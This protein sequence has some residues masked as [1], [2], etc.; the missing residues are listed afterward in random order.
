MRSV[1]LIN[2]CR[3]SKSN[4][5]S[6]FQSFSRYELIDISKKESSTKA[7]YVIKCVHQNHN[8][9]V[10]LFHFHLRYNIHYN[11]YYILF[12]LFSCHM[13]YLRG[14][15]IYVFNSYIMLFSNFACDCSIE[16]AIIV[17]SRQPEL[18]RA[19]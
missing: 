1:S 17:A 18:I 9:R 13:I 14:K 6:P 8:I 5:S 2:F 11:G 16:F 15:N 10:T 3:S 4:L 12:Q 7:L 19:R